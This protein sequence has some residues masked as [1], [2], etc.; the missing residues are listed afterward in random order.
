VTDLIPL[1]PLPY[2][3]QPLFSIGVHDIDEVAGRTSLE[4]GNTDGEPNMD[5]GFGW[6][7]CTTD[8]VLATKQNFYDVLVNIPYGSIHSV[9]QRTW[10]SMSTSSKVD[11]KAS[12]RDLRR[13]RTLRQCQK[14]SIGITNA[15]SP[16]A[17]SEEAIEETTETENSHLLPVNTEEIFDDASSTMD[18]TLIEPMS[19]SALAYNSFMWWASAGEKRT[20]LE[21]EAER[22]A[23]LWRDFNAYADATT[24]GSSRSRRR[25]SSS[26]H[27]ANTAGMSML[28]GS[29]VPE[30]AT[31]GYFHRL[32]ANILGTLATV[33][34]AQ[35]S[36]H[37]SAE[38]GREQN[39]DSQ[40]D[41]GQKLEKSAIYVTSEDMT[42]MGLDVWSDGDRHFIEELV[43]LYWG[44]A[45]EVAGGR[46]ECCGV[47]IV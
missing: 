2:R 22:D 3:L 29:A 8:N 1:E 6:V 12:Q 34:D 14:R 39:G 25:S 26:P 4:N 33:V 36:E 45:A 32:T 31:I 35:D 47:R 37:V 40:E 27:S 46:I 16:F 11:V 10:P 42:R 30:M 28:D 44:R 24:P 38:N 43:E 17:G 7:A 18:E 19:W 20:D 41:R 23:A 15:A 5:D 13:Y 21:E 9:R